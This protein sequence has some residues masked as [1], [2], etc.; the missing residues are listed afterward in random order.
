MSLS[1]TSS[2]ASAAATSAANASGQ[3][4]WFPTLSVLALLILTAVAFWVVYSRQRQAIADLH[5]QLL[6][7]QQ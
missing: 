6:D 3:I 2:S 5:Q 1:L 4:A 7:S